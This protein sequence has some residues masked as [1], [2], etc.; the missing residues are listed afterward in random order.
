M[1]D[2]VCLLCNIYAPTQDHEVEQLI[3]LEHFSSCCKDFVTENLIIGGDFNEVLNPILDR[4]N[5]GVVNRSR[6][7]RSGL[8]DFMD[9]YAITDVWRIRHPK[10]QRYSFHRKAQASRIDFC[11]I[12]D[13]LLNK[14]EKNEIEAGVLSDHSRV[15]LNLRHYEANRGPGLWKFNNNLAS[16]AE[17]TKELS[18]L[19]DQKKMEYDNY[20]PNKKWELIK[21][22]IRK[23]TIQY[24]KELRKK[25]KKYEKE[26]QTHLN[27][28]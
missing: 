28:R 14:V 4:K 16:D 22:K 7:Y 24:G 23:F 8:S 19:I 27:R 1:E 5:S 3:T 21:Y 13:H 18:E 26:L 17:Y 9:Q 25:D 10:T 2:T 11:L 12:S 20:N 15:I 6:K